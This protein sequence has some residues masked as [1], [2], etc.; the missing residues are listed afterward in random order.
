[1]NAFGLEPS[2]NELKNMIT[3]VDGSGILAELILY[4]NVF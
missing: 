4:T 1:M 3:E 2:Q